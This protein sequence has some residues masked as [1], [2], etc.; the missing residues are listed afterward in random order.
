MIT[1]TCWIL[2]MPSNGAANTTGA[3]IE[4]SPIAIDATANALR[5]ALPQARSR[6]QAVRGTPAPSY[7]HA[8]RT[9]VAPAR[10]GR[11]RSLPRSRPDETPGWG[12]STGQPGPGGPTSRP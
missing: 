8:A 2:W 5:T 12:P 11:A 1:T 6:S 3:A 4:P 9:R 10:T 7:E